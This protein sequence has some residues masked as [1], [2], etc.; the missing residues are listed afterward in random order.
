MDNTVITRHSELLNRL[1][2]ER[3]TMQEMGRV[4]QLWMYPQAHRVMGVI[5]RSGRF[6]GKRFVY[7][8]PQLDSLGKGNIWVSGTP[9]E[10]TDEQIQQLESLMDHEIWVDGGDRL[11]VII[12]CMFN[13][14]TGAITRYLFVDNPLRRLVGSPMTLSPTEMKGFGNHRVL[15]DERSMRRLQRERPSLKETWSNVREQAREEYG[16]VTEEM[17]TAQQ[18]AAERAEVLRQQAAER[19]GSFREQATGQAQTWQQRL[20]E[21]AQT[22]G[23]KIGEQAQELSGQAKELTQEFRE[24]AQELR[25]GEWGEVPRVPPPSETTWVDEA[26]DLPPARSHRGRSGRSPDRAQ[27]PQDPSHQNSSHQDPA[28]QGR[29]DRREQAPNTRYPHSP[30]G[31]P[32]YPNDAYPSHPHPSEVSGTPPLPN[33][34]PGEHLISRENPWGYS[35]DQEGAEDWQH[36]IEAPGESFYPD[37]HYPDPQRRNESSRET[38]TSATER[39]L[40]PEQDSS[41]DPAHP[42][43]SPPEPQAA[44]ANSYLDPN[45]LEQIAEADLEDEDPWV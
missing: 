23:K 1:V 39:G 14:K 34:G 5:C 10:T 45:F 35:D 21:Q 19:A 8:L 41:V 38:T 3:D 26:G 13:R 33:P 27:S 25:T 6:R 43:A 29:Y 7:K 30:D 12:D 42:G 37:P 36:P 40:A 22:W 11:G 44:P 32:L 15:V 4:E 31:R 2:I 24:Q 20:T 17:R 28:H 16:Q 18:Q 9:T